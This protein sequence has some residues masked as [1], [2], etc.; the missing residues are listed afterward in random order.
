MLCAVFDF[1][2][3]RRILIL[4]VVV[5][6]FTLVLS[7]CVSRQL[8]RLIVGTIINPINSAMHAVVVCSYPLFSGSIRFSCQMRQQIL[9]YA[10]V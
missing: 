8:G 7:D 9:I 5:Q 3:C 4:H 10:A 6:L 1:A 2:A